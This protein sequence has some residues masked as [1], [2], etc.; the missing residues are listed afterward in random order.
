MSPAPPLDLQTVVIRS[1]AIAAETDPGELGPDTELS[2]LGLDSL[3]FSTILIEIEDALGAE[4]P[5]DVLDQLGSV[6]EVMTVGDVAGL[7][8][9]W[10]VAPATSGEPGRRIVIARG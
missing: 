9:R 6:D 7:L 1:I 8:S 4:V 3:D 10:T 5:A 2:G